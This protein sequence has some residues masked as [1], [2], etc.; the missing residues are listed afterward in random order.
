MATRYEHYLEAERLLQSAD[1][2]N[3]GNTSGRTS[4][5]ETAKVHAMLASVERHVAGD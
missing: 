2:L 4:L 1:E 3:G 5:V